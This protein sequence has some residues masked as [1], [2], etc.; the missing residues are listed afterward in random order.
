MKVNTAYC[1]GLQRCSACGY[2][3]FT[4]WPLRQDRGHSAFECGDCGELAAEIHGT[5]VVVW[6]GLFGELAAAACRE[7]IR[8]TELRGRFH[9]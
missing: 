9:S 5:A 8:A 4:F 6:S 1:A 7:A 3:Q 2:T